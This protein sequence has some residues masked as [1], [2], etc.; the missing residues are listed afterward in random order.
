MIWCN[1]IGLY[2]LIFTLV[3]LIH[4]DAVLAE[5]TSFLQAQTNS[6]NLSVGQELYLENC[7]SCHVPIPAQVLP[8]ESWQDILNQT[9]N[10]YGQALSPSIKAT[11]G[12]IWTYLYR[13]SRPVNPEETIPQYVANS[14]YLRALH[15]QVELPKPTTH[16]TCTVCHPMAAKLDYRTLSSDY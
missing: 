16:Q 8:R 11:A 15:P 3:L 6:N 10:H 1:K 4:V 14:R 7:S 9:Q 2:C 13:Y 12:L 5:N